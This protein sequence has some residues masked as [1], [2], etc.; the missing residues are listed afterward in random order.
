VVFPAFA[1][2][3]AEEH[4]LAQLDMADAEIGR[5]VPARRPGLL[6]RP[7]RHHAA[8]A[9][10]GGLHRAEF[11]SSAVPGGADIADPLANPCWLFD[12][13]GRG[14]DGRHRGR[15]SSAGASVIAAAVFTSSCAQRDVLQG[16]LRIDARVIAEL[17]RHDV[18]EAQG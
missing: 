18:K 4:S 5:A 11:G 13:L 9:P 2:V 10:G 3:R 8:G 17:V 1:P 15:D 6:R 14:L 12:A 16:T 7:P